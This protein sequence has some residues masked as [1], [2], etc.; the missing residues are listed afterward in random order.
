MKRTILFLWILVLSMIIPASAAKRV[1]LVIGNGAYKVGPLMNPVND[2]SDMAVKLRKLGFD[3]TLLKNADQRTMERQIGVFRNKLSSAEIRLFYYAGHGM[4]VKG[5]NYLIPVNIEVRYEDDIKYE[6]VDAGRVLDSMAAAG[7]GANIVI[8]DACRDNPFA[9]SFRSSSRGLARMPELHGSI[10]VYATAPGDVAADGKGRNGLF[11]GQLLR[12]I[13]R[14]GLTLEQ[15]FKKTGKAVSKASGNRQ[16]PWMSLG[17][18]DDVYLA[19]S[20]PPESGHAVLESSPG[21]KSRP[22][23]A[24][25]PV[26]GEVWI[27]PT[28]GMEFVWVPGGC[29][30]MGS[31]DR[32]DDEKPVHEVCVDGFWMGK[33]EVTNAQYRRFRSDHE[34]KTVI[35]K[36]GLDGENQPVIEVSWDDAKEYTDWLS[37]KEIGHYRLPTE[38]EWEYAARAGTQTTWYWGDSEDF[39]C[40]YANVHDKSSRRILGYD[41]PNVNCDDGYALT[42]PVGSYRPNDFGLYDMIG[43]VWEWCEDIYDRKAYSKHDRKNPLHIVDGDIRVC[44][45][46]CWGSD[47]PNMVVSERYGWGQGGGL[48]GIGFR[49]VRTIN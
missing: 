1:A 44:R 29:Y 31:N 39:T 14:P 7:K 42:A 43:N 12:Y 36:E 9:R 11:T 3:V 18:Y 48:S 45:G 21:K 19:G 6:A 41:Y 28:T 13:N 49:V 26:K 38:A 8:L 23:P 24:R 16:R 35:M 34:S 27:E 20:T 17:I 47:P 10:I 40:L 2:A 15:V 22:K 32:G 33:Y 5:V 30:M 37:S 46:A 25:Q 4:Q